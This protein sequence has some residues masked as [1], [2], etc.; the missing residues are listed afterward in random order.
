MGM[1]D[2]GVLW[3]LGSCE[4]THIIFCGYG[5]GMGIE[6]PSPRQP[7]QTPAVCLIQDEIWSN[8]SNNGAM[9]R[10][11]VATNRKVDSY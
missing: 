10:S 8:F 7:C 9:S 11:P 5:M 6:I 3:A 4:D 1:Q 2:F